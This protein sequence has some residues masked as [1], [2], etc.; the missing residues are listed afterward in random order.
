MLKSKSNEHE[1]DFLKAL[2]L[3]L[4]QQGYERNQI[5]IITGYTGQVILLK[6]L[7]PKELFEGVKIKSVDNF[8]GE[9]NDIILLSLVRSNK[10]GQVGFMK[11]ENRAC[12]CLSRAK[13]G[14]YVIGNFELFEKHETW[15]T[16]LTAA[17]KMG[18]YGEK[19][20]LKC[21]NHPEAIVEVSKGFDFRHAPDG[22]CMK[23][24][25]FRLPCGH[26]CKRMCHVTDS[27]HDNYRCVEIC[28]KNECENKEHLCKDKC[29][30]GTKC[31]KCN[32]LVDKI[33]PSC[34][35]TQKL[36]CHQEP[37]PLLCQSPC[38]VVLTCGH[39]CN[40]KC[41]KQCDATHCKEKVEKTLPCGHTAI[42]SCNKPL[43]NIQ[44]FKLIEKR[45]LCDHNAMVACFRPV[46]N[47]MCRKP[48]SQILGCGHT[49]V[50]LCGSCH[51][52]RLHVKCNTKCDRVL[53]CSH[54][55]KEPC[56]KNCPPCLKDC[57]NICPHSRCRHIC[58]EICT[59]CREPCKWYC[60]HEK[61]SKLCYEI[62]DR[63]RCNKP[64]RRK[65][66]C[67]HPCIGLCTELCPLLCRVCNKDQVE[68]IFFGTEDDPDA[69]FV[70]L[71]DCKHMFEVNSLDQ[72]MEM[73]VDEGNIKL[74]ECPKCKTLIRKSFRY[75]TI[76]RRVMD[77]INQVKEVII[78]D[79]WEMEERK[80]KALNTIEKI[81]QMV[82]S[83]DC[84]EKRDN[85]NYDFIKDLR[86][87]FSMN[88]YK[89]IRSTVHLSQMLKEANNIDAV[90]AVTNKINL[91][92]KLLHLP[93]ILEKK[94]L[95]KIDEAFLKSLAHVKLFIMEKHLND[96]QQ[97]NDA[98]NE[99]RRL[100]LF[101]NVMLTKQVLA[102]SKANDEERELMLKTD[103]IIVEQ[104]HTIL[105][106][107][108]KL[109]D[110]VIDVSM[111]ELKD[112]TERNR[113]NSVLTD[114]ERMMIV[115]AV[116]G[117]KKGAW[118]KCPNGHVYAIGDCGG[119]TVKSRCPEC[120]GVIGGV[121]H[122]LVEGN[123]HA[124]EFDNSNAA[125]WSE[126]ANM[127]NYEFMD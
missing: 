114:K 4:L 16:I 8:Q 54:Q 121:N 55:C 48:C 34:Q 50:G 71:L 115:S 44:C 77:D 117:V 98:L 33:I 58:G 67:R 6:K 87:A 23:K 28:A 42:V 72:W 24:C 106:E 45:L 113:I 84:V 26:S 63:A 101:L 120:K 39:K 53:V 116:K 70:Q 5:T 107:G 68:E 14:L 11:Y 122:A 21:Q 60:R 89:C 85:I 108:K 36:Y 32:I 65:L 13:I 38:D 91:F 99:I 86:L 12:V 88:K 105:L 15:A 78:G 61:C 57:R 109:D 64:C 100:H 95:S 90:N 25:D 97:F 83:M 124:A 82:I 1:A 79:A 81:D 18:S 125:A 118:Y 9:E 40:K 56:T 66:K 74:K 51:Q 93:K 102:E 49:C 19:L 111:K 46:E 27:N 43:D 127:R 76:I 22:G 126:R 80:D 10:E 2:C 119:A 69:R 94:T 3:Y 31:G 47:E 30:F 41:G 7:M 104:H 62:C 110:A 35:H 73:G 37:L 123:D 75:G 59:P 92:E 103:K 17:K 20:T 112:L 52:G 96:E 29:H